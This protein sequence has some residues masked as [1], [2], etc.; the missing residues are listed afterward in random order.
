MRQLLSQVDTKIRER[1]AQKNPPMVPYR[2]ILL[3]FA[4]KT[5]RMF[6]IIGFCSA[7]ICGLGLPSFV[8]LFGDI[9]DSFA[10]FMPVS[11]ILDRIQRVAMILTFIGLG[12]WGFSYL[13]FSFLIIASERIG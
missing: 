12:V 2:K 6:L 10:A 1:E 8:F 11:E 13:F 3:T 7:I 4:D 5:D 9:A